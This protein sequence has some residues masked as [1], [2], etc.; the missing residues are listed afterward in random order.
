MHSRI[1]ERQ[2]SFNV[3][4]MSFLINTKRNKGFSSSNKVQHYH[5]DG[6]ESIIVMGRPFRVIRKLGDVPSVYLGLTTKP[7]HVEGKSSY[8]Y[9]VENSTRL[10]EF[11]RHLALKRSFFGVDQV[12]EAHKEIEIMNRIKDKNIVRI[13]HSEVSRNEGKLGVSIAMEY[14]GNNLERRIRSGGASGAGVRM[15]E[16]E[17]CHVLLA[18]TSAVGYLHAQQPPI[19]HRDIRPENVLINNNQTG[20]MAYKLCNFGSATTEAYQ[21]ETREEA[22]AA[23]EDIERHTNPGFRAPEMADPW[24]KHRISEKVDLWALGVLVY[25]MMYMQLPFKPNNMALTGN[26]KVKFP[27]S[28]AGRYTP[29]LCNV[30]EH[31]LEPDPEKRW[32]VFA[33]TNFLRFD[34]DISRHLGL[35]VFTE[36]EWPEGWEEQDVKVVGRE[37]PAK[38]APVSYGPSIGER[39]GAAERTR[40]HDDGNHVAATG[41]AG[42]HN[43]TTAATRAAAASSTHASPHRGYVSHGGDA[44]MDEAEEESVREALRILNMG[45]SANDSAAMQQLMREQ[46]EVMEMARRNRRA[47][48][49]ADTP[50]PSRTAA[51]GAKS[52]THEPHEAGTAVSSSV[53][54]DLFAPVPVAPGPAGAA[55]P[56]S[57]SIT[58]DLFAQVTQ[59]P[60]AMGMQ[61]A[62][63]SWQMPPTPAAPAASSFP[64]SSDM[65]GGGAQAM[66]PSSVTPQ[67]VS[68]SS[69][70][71]P[72][73]VMMMNN[74]T[75]TGAAPTTAA[76]GYP[77]DGNHGMFAGQEM[78]MG[79]NAGGAALF[80]FAPPQAGLAS[81]GGGGSMMSTTEMRDRQDV[82]SHS[83]LVEQASRSAVQGKKDPFAELFS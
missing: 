78:M 31:L 24:G 10:A 47:A 6:T 58:D 17:I 34:E 38:Q 51:A 41:D 26:P 77:V 12:S 68:F 61:A 2:T 63:P 54:D 23:I 22:A 74:H 3:H 9:L 56:D 40:G 60:N 16:S 52:P 27:S 13:F 7:R 43:H 46:E 67:S 35:F 53:I 28:A 57:R 75:S 81:G 21:C 33:L 69:G 49:D 15:T 48:G 80:G 66:Y 45:G 70:A 8:I 79:G 44:P 76:P 64:V 29:S 32:D 18:L 73:M 37:Q 42:S 71:P 50:P 5:G 20:P 14:C 36:T 55:A 62:H 19:A 72:S 39:V 83:N 82:N 65:Y 25:Y 11:P 30:I 4:T 59:A 1:D